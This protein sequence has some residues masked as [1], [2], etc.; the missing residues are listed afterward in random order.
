MLQGYV[1]SLSADRL[2]LTGWVQL[3]DGE[4]VPL[5][6]DRAGNQDGTTVF[7]TERADVREARGIA[8]RSFVLTLAAPLGY[9]DAYTKTHKVAARLDDDLI[10]LPLT[11]QAHKQIISGMVT[12][13]LRT[14]GVR[15]AVLESLGVE[16]LGLSKHIDAVKSAGASGDLSPI[17]FPVGLLSPSGTAQIGRDGHL[18]LT[19][20]SNALREQ[21]EAP[22]N[23]T[24]AQQL[25]SR[26]QQWVALFRKTQ[27]EL[28]DLGIPFVQSII[29]EKLT[30]L[31]HLAPIAVPGPTPLYQRVSE[32]MGDAPYYVDMLPLFETWGDNVCGWQKNDSH[33]SPAGSLAMAKALLASLPGCDHRVLD[34][35]QLT[36][37]A[38]LDGDLSNKFFN[39][40]IW[41][42]HHI[43]EPGTL[44]SSAIKQ[45]YAHTP[46]NFVGSHFVWKNE[47]A[48]IQRTVV[49][50]GNSFF[51]SSVE[52][53]ARLGWWFARLF[54]EYHFRWENTVDVEYVRSTHPDFVIAQT[55]ERFLVRPPT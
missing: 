6:L 14:S 11:S 33:C 39:I 16:D 20:G 35:V 1:E 31:R 21:Y 48:P 44:G 17:G 27:R 4:T 53:P 30:A 45:A 15:E 29:P 24:A 47:D 25:E 52:N 8:N 37:E 23:E 18:F 28:L 38:Y 26:A 36:G 51:G 2:R 42:R 43:P 55:I 5:F 12:E 3:N 49:V 50:F 9:V 40:P 41:D 19:G 46:D 22:K 10:F 32:L 54:S 34:D 7:G 13:A